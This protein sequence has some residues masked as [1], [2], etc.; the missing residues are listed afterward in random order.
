M[1][2]ELQNRRHLIMCTSYDWLYY[3]LITVSYCYLDNAVYFVH[4]YPI[5][6]GFFIHK[7][8]GIIQHR[9]N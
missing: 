3:C 9:V 6:A 1:Q 8:I 2:V 5:Q 4:E 7:E